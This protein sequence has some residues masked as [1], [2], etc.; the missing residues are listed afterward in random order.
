[1]NSNQKQFVAELAKLRQNSTF[2]TLKGYRNE[3]SEIAD[4][5][6]IFNISYR[7]ALVKSIE[8]LNKYIPNDD[9][10]SK[11]KQEL[12]DS[13]KTS[14]DKID[15]NIIEDLDPHYDYFFNDDDS[16]IKGIKYHPKSETLHLYGLVA[17]KKVIVPGTYAKKNRQA[18]T[19]VKDKLRKLCTVS[20][21]RQFKMTPSQVD[22]IQVQNLSFLPP[23]F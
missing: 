23:A 16:I 11:A 6:I 7:N 19:I 21:F 1:M 8:T 15:T 22:S 17:H 5:S 18:F 14:I 10:E 12:I 3:A 4:Y 20:K 2:L 9:V 13:Y